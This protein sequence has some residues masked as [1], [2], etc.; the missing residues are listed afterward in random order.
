VDSS[1]AA[2]IMKVEMV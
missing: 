1:A 2:A